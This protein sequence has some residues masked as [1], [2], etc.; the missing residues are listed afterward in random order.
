MQPSRDPKRLIEIMAALRR[1]GTG[2]PWDLEQ[3]FE[4]IVPYA[5]EESYEIADAVARGDVND[6]KEELGDLLLQVVFQARIAE[7]LGFF[8]FGGVVEAITQ[9]MIRRHPHVF[10]AARG[11]TP[12]EVTA[13]WDNIK[14]EE[15]SAKGEPDSTR[16]ESLLAGVPIALPGLTRAVKLQAKAATVG[17]DWNDARLVLKKIREETDEI[18]A[19]LDAEDSTAIADEIGD[20]LF[21]I[22]NLTRHLKAD[23][24]AAIR[25]ANRKF[26]QRF[27]FIEETLARNGTPP[28]TAALTEMEALWNTAKARETDS[29]P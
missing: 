1:P 8:D 25:Q 26:E 5:I 2:C 21:S 29:S 24:E 13:L 10:G 6:L 19:A 23:P 27:R 4:T 12:E 17:F 3:T 22:A 20:L 16:Q 11:F 28:G 15:K 9:K 7:E 14:R 18:E